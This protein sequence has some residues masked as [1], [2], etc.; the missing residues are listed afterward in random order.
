MDFPDEE[1]FNAAFKKRLL[2]TRLALG[3]THDQIAAA[4]GVKAAAY[5]K[6]ETRPRSGFPLYLLPRLI[7]TT[8]KPYSY[9]CFGTSGA[10]PKLKL[11]KK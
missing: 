7:A 6:Y 9:W 10:P 11:I 1:T 2:E 3:L 5:Q 8:D 4:L